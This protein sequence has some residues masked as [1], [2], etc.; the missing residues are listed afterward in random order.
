MSAFFYA[1]GVSGT[2]NVPAGMFIKTISCHAKV[3]GGTCVIDSGNA[4]PIPA[5]VSFTECFDASRE[6][7]L[8]AIA[9]VFS[10]TDSYYV[11]W[12]P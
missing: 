6:T 9:I 4:I 1:A 5:G 7:E 3:D 10:G 11:S 2:V 12:G 8:G